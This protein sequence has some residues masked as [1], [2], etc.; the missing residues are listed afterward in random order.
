MVWQDITFGDYTLHL[1][2]LAVSPMPA[3]NQN[4]AGNAAIT[5]AREL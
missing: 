1:P 3:P 5:L 2:N 4:I